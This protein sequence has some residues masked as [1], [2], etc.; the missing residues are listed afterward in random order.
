MTATLDTSVAPSTDFSK[1]RLSDIVQS[2]PKA[3]FVQ[4]PVK[5]WTAVISN[6]LAVVLGYCAIAYSP[7]FLLPVAWFFTGT[8]LTGFFVIG[9]D[10][11]HRSFAQKTWVND[12]VGHLFMLPLIYPFHSW[13]I[14]HNFHHLH[15]NKLDVDN[16]WRPFTE[17]F[18]DSLPTPVRMGYRAIRGY[19]WWVGSIAHWFTI[20]FDWRTFEGKERG[21]VRFSSL[22]VIGSAAIFFPLLIWQ[23]GIGGFVKFWFIPWMVYHFWMSTFTLVHHTILDV[24]FRPAEEWNAAEAQ[25]AGTIH[26]DYPRWVEWLCH[27]INVHVPHHV[28]TAIPSYNLRMAH[29][30]LKVQWGDVIRECKFSWSLMREIADHCHLYEQERNYQSFRDYRDRQKQH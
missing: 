19:F 8:A 7:W 3:C 22:L 12:F 20:H 23:T 10:S 15:T 25:L 11:G 18:Y 27:D 26:C 4:N 1:L 30:A 29:Q 13:R 16:A 17:E 24:P 21:Q 5:A 14:L 28:S 2:L 9:H 6:V